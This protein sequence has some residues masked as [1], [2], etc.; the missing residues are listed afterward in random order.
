MSQHHTWRGA[1]ATWVVG[2][3]TARGFLARPRWLFCPCSRSTRAMLDSLPRYTP[4]SASMGTMRAGGTAAK[5]GSLAT[6]SSSA[7]SAGLR[8]CAGCRSHGLRPAIARYQPFVGLPAL[9]GAHVDA[10]DLAGQVQPGSG[11]VGRVNVLG[12]AAAIFEADHSS[13]PL[14]KIASTFFDST[15]N[16]AVS[17]SARSLRSN[18]RSNSLMR[19]RS[20]RVAC[21]LARASANGRSG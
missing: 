2:G 15:S 20:L 5:R 11:V 12:Q 8:A 9:Q 6:R 1:V 13:S 4:S 16:A 18:S 17:A 14:R 19:L 21:G 10:G 7:R 3:R